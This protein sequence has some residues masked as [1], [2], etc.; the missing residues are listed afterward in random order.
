LNFHFQYQSYLWFLLAIPFFILLFIWLLNWKRRTSK[1]IGDEGLVKQLIRNFSSSLFLTKFI[2]FLIAFAAGILAA[3]NLRKPGGSDSNIRKGID[4]IIALDVSKSMLAVDLQ[5]NRLER[6]KQMISKLID[7]MPNDRVGLVLFAGRAYLQMPLTVDH[8]AAKMF[9][10]S[11]NPDAIPA[12]GT[13]I[14]EALQTSN[15]AFNTKEHRFKSIILISDG[16]DHD[17]NALKTVEEL[18][19]QGVMISTVGIGSPEGAPIFDPATNSN[20]LDAMG[21]TVISRLNEDE[22]KQIAEKTN[23]IYTKLEST[24]EAVKTLL[25]HMSQ[26]ERKAFGDVALMGYKTYYLWFAGPMF[27]LLVLEFL[28]PERKRKS[29]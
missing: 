2:L 16:E 21:N 8:G 13:V 6:A 24:D 18:S 20:K 29:V 28:I 19:Q 11:A 15:L 9:V 5:P 26:I 4:V 25:N 3:A 23:G 12:Q 22:L 10:S 14:S 17:D 1:K 27:V 7:Q